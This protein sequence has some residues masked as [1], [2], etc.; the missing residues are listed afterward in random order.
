MEC[1][2]KK[3]NIGVIVGIK[4]ELNLL[5]KFSSLTIDHGYKT[6][7]V[8]NDSGKLYIMVVE[9][10][11]IDMFNKYL[12]ESDQDLVEFLDEKNI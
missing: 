10:E 8:K 11:K 7:L 12:L 1:N 3:I 5:K 9:L 4:E 6:A 2:P